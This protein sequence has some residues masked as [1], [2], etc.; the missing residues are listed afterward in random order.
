MVAGRAGAGGSLDCNSTIDE[1]GLEV[2]VGFGPLIVGAGFAWIRVLL[3]KCHGSGS[4]WA[5]CM[6]GASLRL[7]SCS[8]A[9]VRSQA[10]PHSLEIETRERSL[11]NGSLE[12][13]PTATKATVK[14]ASWSSLRSGLW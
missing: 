5:T 11:R 7:S 8:K 4:R 6:T 13:Y 14:A 1:G 9:C 12:A 3:P 2:P 10:C